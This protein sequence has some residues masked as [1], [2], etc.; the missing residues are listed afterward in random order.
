MIA[1]SII[2]SE[3][4]NITGHYSKITDYKKGIFETLQYFVMGNQPLIDMKDPESK[5]ISKFSKIHSS[6]KCKEVLKEI[7]TIVEEKYQSK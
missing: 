6:K 1:E 7:S 5:E 4:N 3:S 2:G